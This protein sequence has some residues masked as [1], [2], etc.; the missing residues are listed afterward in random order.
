MSRLACKT[1]AERVAFLAAQL[2]EAREEIRQLKELLAPEIQIDLPL[3]PAALKMLRALYAHSP[4]VLSR[5]ALMAASPP[6]DG[7]VDERDPKIVAQHIH[8]IR[9]A[10][11]PHGIA[12]SNHWGQ[13]FSLPPS[14]KAKLKAFLIGTESEATT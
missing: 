3:Q 8:F 1:D 4:R 10:L 11:A 9:R 14:E 5:E 13:G 7:A 2:E 12:V 6:L